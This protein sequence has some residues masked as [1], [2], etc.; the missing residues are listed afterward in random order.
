MADCF[1]LPNA[2]ELIGELREDAYF[3]REDDYLC[4][5][6]RAE[7]LEETADTI[8]QLMQENAKLKAER[9]AALKALP[10]DCRTCSN[11]CDIKKAHRVLFGEPCDDYKPELQ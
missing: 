1:S 5:V 4:D 7:I 9:D 3:W 2:A 10:H 11:S 6:R 8:E